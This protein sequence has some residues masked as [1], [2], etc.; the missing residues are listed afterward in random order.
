[1]K[2]IFTGSI[3]LAALALFAQEQEKVENKEEKEPKAIAFPTDKT[4]PQRSIMIIDPKA[5]GEDFVK[6]FDLLKRDKPSSR[7]FYRL[8]N[9]QTIANIIELSL[10]DN[11]T[12]VLFKVTTTQGLKYLV[13]STEDIQEIGHL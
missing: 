4:K 2:K 9:G 10:I 5:R 7:I 6:A 1:M 12:L 3:V 11:G 13:V 8:F